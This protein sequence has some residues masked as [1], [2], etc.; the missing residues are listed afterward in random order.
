MT[1]DDDEHDPP[2]QNPPFISGVNVVDI[3][4]IRVA[5]GFSRRPHSLCGHA[6]MTYD[7]NERRIWC[8]DCRKNVDPFDAFLILVQH[9][10]QGVQRLEKRERLVRESEAHHLISIAAKAL[11]HAW[12]KTKMVPAC[13][14][15]GNG[16]LPEDF[17]GGFYTMS[18]LGREFALAQRARA[19]KE[20]K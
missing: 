8:E 9:H 2:I 12:R 15:C 14:S 20:R 10:H 13:P 4:D 1:T 16:L 11:D 19:K 7:S 5:R 3:G 17:K 18:M 6:K